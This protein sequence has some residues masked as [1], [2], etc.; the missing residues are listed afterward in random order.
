MS[1]AGWSRI[2]DEISANG[3]GS[4]PAPRP[5]WRAAGLRRPAAAIG[6]TL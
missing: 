6:G 1:R 4:E 3:L 2:R 5:L